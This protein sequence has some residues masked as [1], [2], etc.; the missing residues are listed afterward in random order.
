MFKGF[1]QCE[2]EIQ[3]EQIKEAIVEFFFKTLLSMSFL[4]DLNIHLELDNILER[5]KLD[6]I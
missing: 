6:T 5:E 3:Q 4:E 2:E 1:S